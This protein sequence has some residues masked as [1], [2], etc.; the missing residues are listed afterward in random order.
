[1]LSGYGTHLVYVQDRLEFPPPTYEQVADRVRE[2][3]KDDQRQKLNDEYIASLLNRY[4]VII[5]GDDVDEEI[6][7]ETSQ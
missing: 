3:Q 2:D 5:E 6:V 1:V 7:T 4:N